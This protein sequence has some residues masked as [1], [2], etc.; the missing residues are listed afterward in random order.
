[1]P[2]ITSFDT[3]HSRYEEWFS[4]H[5]AAYH[6]ELL[7]LRALVPW[8]GLG[9][10]VGVGTGRFAAPFGVQIGIDPS[11]AMLKYAVDRGISCVQA[12]AEALPFKGESFDHA[13]I[14]TT[15]CFVKDAEAMLIESRRVLKPSGHL[16]IGFIDEASD[17]GQLYLEKQ[18]E[19][20]FYRDAT[21]FSGSQVENLLAEAGFSQQVWGQT[22]TKPLDEIQEIEA[23]RSGRGQGSF[24]VVRAT[25]S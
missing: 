6:S 12:T 7:A 24:L 25:R 15:I 21:F 2:R 11:M 14:V 23:F 20:I 13:L 8:Q 18:H 3:H 22:L 5:E 10:E 16:V 1:M 17:L 19:N 4:K 9:L